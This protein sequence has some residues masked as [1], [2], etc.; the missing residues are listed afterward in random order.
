MPRL[1]VNHFQSDMKMLGISRTDL[2]LSAKELS[3]STRALARVESAQI[4]SK[5]FVEREK[6]K[7]KIKKNS[8]DLL[9]KLAKARNE[10]I[11]KSIQRTSRS[12]FLIDLNADDQ[13]IEEE[14]KVRLKR[15]EQ[16][17]KATEKA[18]QAAKNDIILKALAEASELDTL[19]KE[20]KAIIEE[21]KRLKALL[22]IEK[23]KLRTKDDVIEAQR[24]DKH[25]REAAALFKRIEVLKMAEAEKDHEAEILREALN[26]NPPPDHTM[27]DWNGREYT[28]PDEY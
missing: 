20:K 2:E 27:D 14:N 4:L 6:V 8:E 9:S 12:P 18:R 7:K 26:A 25:R 11:S 19:R 5:K 21:E 10:R 17:Y 22:D 3:E 16:K 28:K 23:S 1:Q 24:A 13:R 15:E